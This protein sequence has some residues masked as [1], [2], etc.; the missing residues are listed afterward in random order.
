MF[1]GGFLI[2]AYA[3]TFAVAGGQPLRREEATV[4]ER[5]AQQLP[6]DAVVMTGDPPGL[7]YHTG[8]RA[9]AIPNEGPDVLLQ[10][11]RRYGAGYL[12]LDPDLPLALQELVEK[13]ESYPG[14]QRVADLGDGYYLYVL[15]SEP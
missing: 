8:R 6:A 7:H 1:A 3:V 2:M 11:A 9:I 5:L 14:M 12:L 10:A 4:Y 13:G 15:E